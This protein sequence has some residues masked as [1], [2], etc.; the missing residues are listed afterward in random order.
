[1][2]AQV[3]CVIILYLV[4][5]WLLMVNG[6]SKRQRE[7]IFIDDEITDYCQLKC[8]GEPHTLC[9]EQKQDSNNTKKNSCPNYKNVLDNTFRTEMLH[10]HNGLRNRFSNVANIANMKM[11]VWDEE[12]ALMAEMW[13]KKC[14]RYEKDPCT[15]LERTSIVIIII[16]NLIVR[17]VLITIPINCRQKI[18]S[19]QPKYSLY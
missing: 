10:G 15:S 16:V 18:H 3:K 19:G 4:S 7:S 13:I 12:L 8:N 6:A 9:N 11:L 2:K 5:Y 14:Q 17:K 1:M